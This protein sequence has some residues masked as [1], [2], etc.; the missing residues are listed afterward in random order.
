MQLLLFRYFVMVFIVCKFCQFYTFVCISL[1]SCSNNKPYCE[2]CYNNTYGVMCSACRQY[3]TGKVLEVSL[4]PSV[5]LSISQSAVCLSLHLSVSPSVCL[6][7]CLSDC[8]SV[9]LSVCSF[10]MRLFVYPVHLPVICSSILP[11]SHYCLLLHTYNTSV[12]YCN[13]HLF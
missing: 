7:V 4:S 13:C 1:F 8:L 5:Y 3:I 12:Q 2:T 6:S 9:C 11:D 10:V